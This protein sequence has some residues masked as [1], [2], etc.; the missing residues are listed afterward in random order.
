MAHTHMR[1]E[2]IP[3]ILHA[4]RGL[5]SG[6]LKKVVHSLLTAYTDPNLE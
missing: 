3:R 1:Q 6:F 2:Q 5:V 4:V